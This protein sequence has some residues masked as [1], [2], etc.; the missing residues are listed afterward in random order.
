MNYYT[1]QLPTQETKTTKNS[2]DNVHDDAH[3][4]E[5]L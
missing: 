3:S 2:S 4:I 1:H 5:K